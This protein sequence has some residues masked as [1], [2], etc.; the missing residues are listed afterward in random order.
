MC[1]QESSITI[2][3]QLKLVPETAYERTPVLT[4]LTFSHTQSRTH[5][6]YLRENKLYAGCVELSWQAHTQTRQRHKPTLIHF[7]THNPH[8]HS[9]ATQFLSI[10]PLRYAQ[11]RHL[12]THA[13]KHPACTFSHAHRHTYLCTKPGDDNTSPSP[14]SCCIEDA[15]ISGAAELLGCCC[16]L[17]LL[18]FSPSA[19]LL[20]LTTPPSVSSPTGAPLLRA[21]LL[22]GSST[23]PSTL[24]PPLAAIG[25]AAAANT[26]AR[27]VHMCVCVCEYVCVHVCVCVCVRA[28]VYMCVCEC[29]RVC[30]CVHVCVCVC[31]CASMCVCVCPLWFMRLMHVGASFCV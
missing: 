29:M 24:T 12:Q 17:C 13:H 25:A 26:V 2:A 11:T 21:F 8:T 22:G 3:Q 14:C 23:P 10:T 30:A 28:C 9:N 27:P 6:T 1:K 5:A 31:A 20:P 4:R 19:T 16:C 7:I 18:N 15:R